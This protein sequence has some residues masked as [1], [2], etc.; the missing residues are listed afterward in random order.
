[1]NSRTRA[2]AS[3]MAR[4]KPSSW[5]QILATSSTFSGVIWKA[6]LAALARLLKSWM[7]SYE[8]MCAGSMWAPD[9]G[10][11]SG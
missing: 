10:K 7:D 1:M 8:E 4:G 5:R 6:G 9:S 2:A 3:S 11:P